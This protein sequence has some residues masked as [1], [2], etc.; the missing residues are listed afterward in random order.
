MVE[1]LF[2]YG[3]DMLGNQLTIGM[4]V[5]GASLILPDMTDAECPVGDQA[6]VT[7]QKAGHLILGQLL[8]K[9]RFF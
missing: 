6:T 3:V 7:A 4:G 1:G 2:F 9:E 8:I 5:K